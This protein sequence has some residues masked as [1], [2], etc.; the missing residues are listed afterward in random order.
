MN[1]LNKTDFPDKEY[2]KFL[3]I[4]PTSNNLEIIINKLNEVIEKINSLEKIFIG[5]Q[6]TKLS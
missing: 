5:C 4:K 2:D 6:N 3:K 1:K